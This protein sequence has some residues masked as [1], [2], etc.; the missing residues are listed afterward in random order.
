MS[1]LSLLTANDLM[2][3]RTDWVQWIIETNT[4]DGD[5]DV[6]STTD[7]TLAKVIAKAM[8]QEERVYLVRVYAQVHPNDEPELLCQWG[9][10]SGK[11]TTTDPQF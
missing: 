1:S 9:R 4:Y 6:T 11:W 8:T 3:V 10:S 5:S 2:T 7:K